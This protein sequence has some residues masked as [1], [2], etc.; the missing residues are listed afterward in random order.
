M[1]AKELDN[2]PI[3]ISKDHRILDG[4]HRFMVYFV[5]KQ[6]IPV[7]QINKNIKDLLKLLKSFKHVEYKE[8]DENFKIF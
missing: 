5:N 3:F 4:H 7:I 1:I 8:I 2:N 6:K